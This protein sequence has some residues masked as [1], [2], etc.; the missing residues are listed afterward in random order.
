MKIKDLKDILSRHNGPYDDEREVVI[1]ISK[2]SIGPRATTPVKSI[3][4]GFDWENGLALIRAE[5]TLV[6]KSKKEELYD[7]SHGLLMYIATKPN[8]KETYEIRE[9]K[10]AL[11]KAGY[12]E[13]DFKK[14]RRLYHNEKLSEED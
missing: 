2:P 10:R 7:L 5:E 11:E 12:T 9:A 8:K 3:S 1:L 4:F 13:E 14:Y 6:P